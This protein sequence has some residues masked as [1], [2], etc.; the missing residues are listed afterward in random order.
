MV[1]YHGMVLIGL[2]P[3]STKDV[4]VTESRLLN[5]FFTTREG[6]IWIT[7]EQASRF[8]KEIAGDFNPLHDPDSRRFCVPGDLLF[9][10]VLHHYGIS[11]EMR[12]Q[13]VDM[14]GAG[15]PLLFPEAPGEHF[16][17]TDP[18]GREYLRVERQGE[19]LSDPYTVEALTRCY[20]SFSGE[21]FPHVLVPLMEQHQVMVNPARPLVI[22]EQMSLLVHE[23]LAPITETVQ[24]KLTGSNM[25]VTGKRGDVRLDYALCV[26]GEVFAHGAKRLL[27]SGLKP[28][29]APTMQALV[30]TYADWKAAYVPAG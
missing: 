13:F 5:A 11:A 21:N 3:S 8:A 1:C 22:Y 4:N 9:A 16:A 18:G 25:E 10:L 27:I 12:F 29:D 23:P 7:P 24:P 17:V 2:D 26:E 14:V 6:L 20:V 28:F 15:V 19:V 30:A